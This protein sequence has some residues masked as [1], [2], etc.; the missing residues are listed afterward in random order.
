MQLQENAAICDQ[1]AQ[2]QESIVTVKEERRFLLKK[3]MDLDGDLAA[4]L[5]SKALAN[6]Q[7][8]APTS[9]RK[10]YKKRAKKQKEEE[11]EIPPEFPI[12][13]GALS[14]LSIGEIVMDRPNY[15]ND[16]WIYPVGF[17]SKRNYAHLKERDKKSIYTCRIVENG[18]NPR[19][20][21]I[22][23][24]DPEFVIAAPTPDLCHAA[25]IQ[26]I[27]ENTSQNMELCAQGEWFFGLATSVVVNI[28]QKTPE[29]NKCANFKSFSEDYCK[30]DPNEQSVSYDAFDKDIAIS[31]YNTVL[32]VKEEPPDE[33][34][35]QTN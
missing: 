19:F 4:E 5:A 25:L 26:T 21:I 16:K 34:F 1:V 27:N 20:E 10:P 8:N 2:V 23:E 13:L 11:K 14:I 30:L 33:L 9:T 18:E 29:I 17:V 24:F 12:D 22:P 28:L 31:N 32:E 3:L 15:H 35:E 6:N 7:Q